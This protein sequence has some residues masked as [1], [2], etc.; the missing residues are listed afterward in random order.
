MTKHGKGFLERKAVASM[1]LVKLVAVLPLLLAQNDLKLV[2]RDH[3]FGVFHSVVN[4]DSRA[5]G[6]DEH[7]NWVEVDQF[8]ADV[9]HGQKEAF[10]ALLFA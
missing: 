1:D 7:I 8:G 2:R 4:R 5:S 10:F 6:V 3:W 9:L